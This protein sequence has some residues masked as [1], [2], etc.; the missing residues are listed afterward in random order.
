MVRA[1]LL[2]LLAVIAL[3]TGAAGLTGGVDSGAGAPSLADEAILTLDGTAR[4]SVTTASADVGTALAVQHAA[5]ADRLD[6]YALEARFQNAGS[7]EARRTMLLESMATVETQITALR[8]DD[9]AL[10][11]AYG[12]QEI[13]T[14]A[15]LRELAMIHARAGELRR[16]LDHIQVLASDIPQFSLNE[17]VQLLDTTLYGLE[18]PGR[19]QALAAIHGEAEPTPL[20]VAGTDQGVVLS[21]IV[22]GRFTREAYRADHRDIGAGDVLSI[23]EADQ[24]AGE[25]YP[26]SYNISAGLSTGIRYLSGGVHRIEINLEEG[27]ITAYLDSSTENVFFEV[28]ERR[29]DFLA[30]R[31]SV[32]GSANGT[33]IAVNRSYP[34]GPLQV[35]VA[36]NE[37]RE[38]VQRTVVVDGTRLETDADGVA[39]TLGPPRPFEV[40]AVGPR[41]N[42]TVSVRPFAPTPVGS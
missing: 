12:A 29:L 35:T 15:F 8:S 1:V 37:T 17:E 14:R 4:T 42:V 9:R 32:V 34:G 5:G 40:T 27:V 20:F 28:Q 22:D 38:P 31:P 6:R 11:A 36:D 10:R 30:P 25:L 41:G 19:Q 24:R 33:W 3:P 7:R 26:I 39:W 2:A 21:T 16:T 23:N 13:D 18:G